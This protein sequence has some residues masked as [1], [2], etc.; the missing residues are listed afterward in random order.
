MAFCE[1]DLAIYVGL[2]RSA[3]STLAGATLQPMRLRAVRT[4]DPA[5]GRRRL[6]PALRLARKH[7]GA[8]RATGL[9]FGV[10][11]AWLV[12]PR[13]DACIRTPR[14]P[15]STGML[16]NAACEPLSPAPPPRG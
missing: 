2:L 8:A 12:L 5:D 9:L 16:R 11:S 10:A 3:C 6:H 15:A 1:R 4:A 13:L 14:Q 7:L